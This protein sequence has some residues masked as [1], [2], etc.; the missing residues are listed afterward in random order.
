MSSSRGTAR[1]QRLANTTVA[2]LLVGR[3]SVPKAAA[4]LGAPE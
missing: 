3:G 4:R 1:R 2:D